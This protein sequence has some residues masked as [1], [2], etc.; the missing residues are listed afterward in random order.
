MERTVGS[1]LR[2]LLGA[3]VDGGED[4]DDQIEM[5]RRVAYHQNNVEED[6]VSHSYCCPS[7]SWRV[8]V[9]PLLL[10]LLPLLLLSLMKTRKMN[11]K[12]QLH[13]LEALRK[14]NISIMD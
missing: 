10:L 5:P 3:A 4:G 14:P 6:S 9:P 2:D 12:D 13:S 7:L 11:V 8:L 1:E